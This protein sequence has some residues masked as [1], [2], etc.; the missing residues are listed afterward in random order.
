MRASLGGLEHPASSQSPLDASR[1]PKAPGR[2]PGSGSPHVDGARPEV[3]LPPSHS[4]SH[5]HPHSGV[6]SH[7]SRRC[8]NWIKVVRGGQGRA[9]SQC[10]RRYALNL[11]RLPIMWPLQLVHAPPGNARRRKARPPV[12]RIVDDSTS[13]LVHDHTTPYPASSLSLVPPSTHPHRRHTFPNC[14]G[15][16]SVL[17]VSHPKASRVAHHSLLIAYRP[18]PSPPSPPVVIANFVRNARSPAQ[19]PTA[20]PLPSLPVPTASSAA[21]LDVG[22]PTPPSRECRT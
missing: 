15:F 8:R 12:G 21:N 18:S 3:S 1:R 4:H 7:V 13:R 11:G 10:R 6:T 14:P 19:A 9:E 22:L 16:P 5:S 20:N 2:G 17:F